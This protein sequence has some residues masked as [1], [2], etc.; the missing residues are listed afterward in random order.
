M[1]NYAG[2]VVSVLSGAAWMLLAQSPTSSI[3]VLRYVRIGLAMEM[4]FLLPLCTTAKTDRLTDSLRFPLLDWRCAYRATLPGD[5]VL[6]P[7]F[8][9][10]TGDAAG[11]SAARCSTTPCQSA[12][13]ASS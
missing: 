10:R 11:R 2:S 6:E 12:H 13:V 1:K 5:V 7:P 3:Y 4:F 9:L 8:D